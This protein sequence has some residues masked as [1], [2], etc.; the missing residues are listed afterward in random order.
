MKT[1]VSSQNPYGYDR[2]GW[3]WEQVPDGPAHL[4][5]GCFKG[6]FL[7]S[8]EC[9]KI[10]RRVGVDANHLAIDTARADYP[11][12]EF[13]HLPIGQ[14]L[15]FPDQTFSSI[16]LMEVLEHVANQ[17]ALLLELRRVLKDDGQLIITVPRQHIFSCL[18]MGNFKF[19]FPRLHRWW[20][21]RKHSEEA[22]NKRYVNN[23]DGLIG[24]IAAEKAWHEHFTP[25]HLN[26]V[27][28]KAGFSAVAFAGIG[29]FSRPLIMLGYVTRHVPP[30]RR[31]QQ[32]FSA[33]DR[34]RFEWF[35][36]FCVARK[37]QDPLQ[38]QVN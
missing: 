14:P 2:Y 7:A 34:R 10:A 28:G 24:D 27:L 21:I 35:T 9:K 29:L 17:H 12:L 4:D 36:L 18:D 5:F 30:I 31:L 38:D 26:K 37:Q 8:L 25:Q 13:H 22:Y 1:R 32:R 33:W 11:Q 19:R 3:A 20:Y 15:P 6:Q 16:T 23:P